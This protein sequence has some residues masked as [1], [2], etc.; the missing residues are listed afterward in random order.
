MLETILVATDGSRGASDAVEMASYLAGTSGAKLI[1]LHVYPHEASEELRRMA[2][3]EHLVEPATGPGPTPFSGGAPHVSTGGSA[4]WQR[5]AEMSRDVIEVIGRQI[6]G[7]AENLAKTKGVKQV[8]TV[9][10]DG[11]PA[12]AILDCATREKADLIVMGRR[13]L[14][15]LAGLLMGSVSHKVSHL[16]DC[17]CLTVK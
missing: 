15:D 14:S 10:E 13:G 3:S 12:R 7:R 9:A 2:E 11:D 8:R 6:L 16:A 5:R 17:A 1:V 4:R